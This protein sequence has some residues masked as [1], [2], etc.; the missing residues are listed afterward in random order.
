VSA[1]NTINVLA[2]PT[3]KVMIA[4]SVHA[5]T[6]NHGVMHHMVIIL[7]TI[8]PNV[9]HKEPV[10]VKLVNANVLMDTKVMPAVA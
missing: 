8:I 9:H 1:V 4:L 7:H 3:G 6:P 2:M 5:H 10:I